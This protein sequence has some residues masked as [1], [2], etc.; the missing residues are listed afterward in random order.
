[1]AGDALL[2]PD[3][4]KELRQYGLAPQYTP[5]G[6]DFTS[7]TDRISSLVLDRRTRPGWLVLFGISNLLLLAFVVTV[8][9]LLIKGVGIWGLNIPVAWCFDITSFVW[10]IGIGH[11]GTLI[12]A[13]LLLMH[14]KW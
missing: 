10:W 1:M 9:Y 6:Q 8:L 3:V 5:S 12:S 2:P 7:L 13:F 4:T 14:Q 11:A